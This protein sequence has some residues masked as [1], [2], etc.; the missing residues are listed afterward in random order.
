MSVTTIEVGDVVL[1]RVL[2]LDAA[3][4]PEATGLTAQEVRSVPW[5]EPLW[6]DGDQVRAAACAWVIESG[7]RTIVVDP[8][9]NID[10]ILH[11]PGTT[12]AHQQAFA[13]AF[14]TAGIDPGSVDTVLLSHIESVGLAAVRATDGSGNWRPFFPNSRVLMSD[15]ALASFG[16]LAETEMVAEAFGVLVADGLIDTFADGD[17]LAPGVRAEWTGAHN[18]GHTAFHVGDLDAPAVTFVGHLA[19]TPLHLATGPCRPQHAE[20]ERAWEWLQSAAVDGRWLVGPLWPSP[21]AVR[22]VDNRFVEWR[23]A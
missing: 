13:A 17:L 9:G 10:D 22:K 14:V 23:A 11:D 1:T 4:D 18:P 20:P 6:A 21:G 5:A 3:I 19:V 2:Y 16:T 15:T 12:E 7:G 8:A